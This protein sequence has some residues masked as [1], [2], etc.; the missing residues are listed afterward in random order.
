MK[1]TFGTLIPSRSKAFRLISPQASPGSAAWI[2]RTMA[3]IRS[4]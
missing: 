3:S 2:W 4:M 1:R